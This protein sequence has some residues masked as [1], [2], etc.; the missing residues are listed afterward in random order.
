MGDTVNVA[1]RLEAVDKES[2]EAE[3]DPLACRIIV[4][5][6][7]RARLGAAFELRDL[8]E[9]GLKGKGVKLRIYRV[10]GEMR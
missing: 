10:L 8:G 1:A 6:S 5:E 2:F 4:S 3:R 9:H 7:T